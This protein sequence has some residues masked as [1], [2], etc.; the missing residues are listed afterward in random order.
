MYCTL[1]LTFYCDGTEEQAL[2]WFQAMLADL[3]EMLR[4]QHP[5]IEA[6]AL[7]DR[8]LHPPGE[9]RLRAEPLRRRRGPHRPRDQSDQQYGDRAD[10]AH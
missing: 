6:P 7:G 2:P 10:H 5:G 8:Q 4:A 3:A 1:D 9:V